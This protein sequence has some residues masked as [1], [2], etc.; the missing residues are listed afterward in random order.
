MINKKAQDKKS[1]VFSRNFFGKKAQGMSTSTIVLLIL[2]I[3]ILVVL[4]LGFTLGWSRLVPYISSN[5]IDS[6]KASCSISCSTDAQFEY[7]SVLREVNDGNNKK[8]EETCYN[9]AINYDDRGYGVASCPQIDCGT[10][11][12]E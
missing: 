6:I 2:G 9:L 5:N 4:V 10:V 12:A 3:I 7:C 8:F 1:N 11:S